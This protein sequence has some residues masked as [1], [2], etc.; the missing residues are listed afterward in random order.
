M[1]YYIN[2]FTKGSRI[3]GCTFSKF[4]FKTATYLFVQQRELLNIYPL[5]R[6]ILIINRF[7][8]EFTHG[9]WENARNSRTE[10]CVIKLPEL[11]S[12]RWK[13]SW[14]MNTASVAFPR[15]HDSSLLIWERLDQKWWKPLLSWPISSCWLFGTNSD[16]SVSVAKS[17]EEI[18]FSVKIK[19]DVY[20]N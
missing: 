14:A 11:N 3:A 5:I 2:D 6:L 9:G 1:H 17:T 18:T 19:L 16:L 13:S 7:K 12:N 4:E 20:L 15:A 10:N 8:A